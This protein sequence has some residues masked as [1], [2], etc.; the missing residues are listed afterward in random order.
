[1]RVLCLAFTAT[2]SVVAVGCAEPAPV[3][4]ASVWA[5]GRASRLAYRCEMHMRGAMVMEERIESVG[6]SPTES[7]TTVTKREETPYTSVEW[8]DMELL[9]RVIAVPNL[10]S[11]R[12]TMTVRRF[13]SG[14]T[15]AEKGGKTYEESGGWKPGDRSKPGDELE[16]YLRDAKFIAVIGPKGRLVGSDITGKYWARRKKELADA[17]KKGASQA[18]ADMALR[19]QTPGVFAAMDDA[20]A[21]LP[22]EPAQAGLSWPVRREHVLPYHAYG[23]YMLT[24]GCS[25]SKEEARCTVQSV[26]CRGLDSIATIAIRG[27]RFPRKPEPS[28]PQRVKYF[29]LKGELEA[30]LSTG[31]IEKLRIE[32]VP[33][34]VRPKEENFELKF[35]EV[36]TLKPR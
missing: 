32:S 23:F 10:V 22:P 21:Y 30:N 11:R 29:D 6:K 20:M 24:N 14:S 8:A 27:K 12:V 28:M 3:G 9:L 19:W 1:M 36:I 17:V 26:K 13:R 15:C 4:R 5:P 2:L 25:H 35:V 16:H 33:A 18:Q 34:W 7:S 31:A